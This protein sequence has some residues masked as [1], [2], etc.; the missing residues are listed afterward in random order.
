MSHV[1]VR[2]VPI[3]FVAM[4][5]LLCSIAPA[6]AAEPYRIYMV[7]S[8][9]NRDII[10]DHYTVLKGD[11]ILPILKRKGNLPEKGLWRS[12]A[13][14]KRFNPHVKNINKI[15]PGQELLVPI[16]EIRARKGQ[17]ADGPRYI[18][19]PAVPEVLYTIHEV[20]PGECVSKTVAAC[21]GLRWDQLPEDYIRTFKRLN[22][23][24]K[25]IDSLEPG[26]TI[27]IPELTAYKPSA[28]IKGLSTASQWR[29]NKPL[30]TSHRDKT[31]ALQVKLPV[32][33]LAYTS[34]SDRSVPWW[35]EIVLQAANGLN[36]KLFLSGQC[37]FPRKRRADFT[38][39]LGSF[40]VIELEDGRHFI[41]ETEKGLAEDS[42]KII[43]AFWKS[44]VIIR[45]DPMQPPAAALDKIFCAMFGEKLHEPLDLEARDGSIQVT[46]RGD[47][48][49]RQ[50]SITNVGALHQCITL[51]SHPDE[52][53][54]D[55]V[56]DYLAET[57]V[58][59]ADVMPHGI[60][61]SKTSLAGKDT[62]Y[63]SMERTIDGSCQETFVSTLAK[64]MGYSYDPGVPLS[65]EYSGYPI[66]TAANIIYVENGSDIVVDFG[67]FY[68]E[69]KSAV[70]AIG[71]KVL[72]LEPQ[73]DLLVIAKSILKLMGVTYTED[74]VLFPANRSRSKTTS[75]TIH[76]LLI[77]DVDGKRTLLTRGPLHSKIRDY[78]S[79]EQ[80]MLFKIQG[81]QG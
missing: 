11:E 8:Y 27:R 2:E 22:P 65:F 58:F 49:F 62:A 44:L 61:K 56:V 4:V 20:R 64:A 12:V 46:L 71:V 7:K 69:A 53:T 3:I 77:S 19:I 52:R 54:P 39:D 1:T 41:L 73:E 37:Y 60:D 25:D 28:D 18:T 29:M 21:L 32:L 79:E 74:P 75:L 16:K 35:K 34:W 6:W 17:P 33:P 63:G 67:T 57:G 14:L 55:V 72:S 31:E 78:L 38:L 45:I 23:G 26:Q 59:L 80:I 36:V 9:G 68:G 24:I 70:E 13:I 5:L 30:G 66:E 42:E 48:V 15:S 81:S 51:I 47:W 76:G 40:P 10:F 50:G 43:R